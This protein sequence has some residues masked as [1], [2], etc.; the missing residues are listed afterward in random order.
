MSSAAP[1][2]SGAWNEAVGALHRAL[3][4]ARYRAIERVPTAANPF[5]WPLEWSNL[6]AALGGG[7]RRLME[8]SVAPRLHRD[9]F[10][11]HHPLQARL[12]GHFFLNEAAPRALWSRSLAQLPECPPLERLLELE[13]LAEDEAGI[14]S[15]LRFVPLSGALLVTDRNDRSIPDFVYLGRDSALFSDLLRR[16]LGGRRFERALDLCCGCGVQ[17]LTVAPWA[18]SVEGSDINPRAIAFAELNARLSGAPS[19]PTFRVADLAAGAGRYDL[20]VANPPYVWMP[21]A[22]R[23]RNRDGYGGAL[24]LEIVERILSGLDALLTPHGELHMVAESPVLKGRPALPELMER[25]LK[26]S[27]IGVSLAP[28]YYSVNRDHADFQ[29]RQGSSHNIYYHAHASRD[30]PPGMRIRDL[31]WHRRLFYSTYVRVASRGQGAAG[32]GAGP[33]EREGARV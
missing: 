14:R 25:V 16:H 2:G 8:H 21:E 5:A 18:G 7:G 19:A 26:G 15:R 23:T 28:L 24:G 22:E 10:G 30:L 27:R 6:R 12:L 3:G 1:P 29:R 11:L 9:F 4:R 20:V 33:N 31:G 13:I 17:A 32:V